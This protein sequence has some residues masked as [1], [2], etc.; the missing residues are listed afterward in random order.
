MRATKLLSKGRF[1]GG[2]FNDDLTISCVYCFLGEDFDV[3]VSLY[4]MCSS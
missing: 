2:T 3:F 1:G 4:L